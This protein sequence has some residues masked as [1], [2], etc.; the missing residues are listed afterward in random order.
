MPSGNITN[1]KTLI[2]IRTDT[3]E[4]R[5]WKE[6]AKKRAMTLSQYLRWLVN[7]D[8]RNLVAKRKDV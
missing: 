6:Q 1:M 5:H 3:T 7:N 8:F 2:N 4:R